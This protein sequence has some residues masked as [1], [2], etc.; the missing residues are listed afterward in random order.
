MHL[1]ERDPGTLSIGE[2][3]I[4]NRGMLLR[5]VRPSEQAKRNKTDRPCADWSVETI[6]LRSASS[7]YA[8]YLLNIKG[9]KMRPFIF[10]S[11]F[12][13]FEH[14]PRCVRSASRLAAVKST[15]KI[16]ENNINKFSFLY[17]FQWYNRKY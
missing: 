17:R 14:S 16:I 10:N 12:K 5:L 7:Q 6:S 3:K 2:P 9:C 13:I 11:C 8:C 1:L 4:A 15:S